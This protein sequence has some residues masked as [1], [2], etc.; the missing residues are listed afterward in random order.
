[1]DAS[2][3]RRSFRSKCDYNSKTVAYLLVPR[4]TICTRFVR[5]QPNVSNA[6]AAAA[7]IDISKTN[8]ESSV[9]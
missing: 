3:D 6:V 7:R 5:T 9:V 2:R 1:M 4:F 8:V